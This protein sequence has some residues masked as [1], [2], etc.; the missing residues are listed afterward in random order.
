[1]IL[2]VDTGI[3]LFIIGG[4]LVILS[5]REMPGEPLAIAEVVGLL[6]AFIG[7][8][9]ALGAFLWGL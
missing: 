1:M 9:V 5:P 4:C 2:L 7:F 6:L 8:G 3:F